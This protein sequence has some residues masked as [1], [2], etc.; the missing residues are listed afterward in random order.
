MHE[1]PNHPVTTVAEY[2]VISPARPV[3][4]GLVFY[5]LLATIGFCWVAWDS[6]HKPDAVIAVAGMAG[7]WPMVW[8]WRTFHAAPLSAEEVEPLEREI[9]A[10]WRR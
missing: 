2:A 7:Q 5:W 10:R 9:K 6:T 8:L 4:W 1:P 3:N